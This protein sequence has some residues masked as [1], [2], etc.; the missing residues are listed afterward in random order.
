MKKS[1]NIILIGYRGTGKSS[2][3]EVLSR[4]TGR[5]TL[6][7]DTEIEKKY[8][9]IAEIVKTSGWEKFRK[10]E[11][12]TL[13]SLRIKGGIIDCGGGIIETPENIQILNK[14][15]KVFWLKASLS[16]IHK[17]LEGK[18]DRPALTNRGDFLQ[19]IEEVLSRR[20]S[21]YTNAADTAIDTDGKS[22]LKIA[23]EVLGIRS[24]TKICIPVVEKTES[25][26][27]AALK[28]A[29]LQADII[30]LRVDYLENIDTHA[31]ENIIDSAEKPLIITCRLQNQ[32]G[33]GNLTEKNRQDL[34]KTA[35]QKRVDFIDLE[36]TSTTTLS[37]DSG[38]KIIRSHHSFENTPNLVDIKNILCAM[39]SKSG[40]LIKYIPTANSINDNF[41]I[42]QILEENKNII[43]FCMGTKGHISRVL[44]GKYG[45]FITFAAQ[46]PEQ[47]SAPGQVG[48][49]ELV[50][51]Y[52]FHDIDFSTKVYGIIGQYA[53][54]S[55]SKYLHNPVFKKYG[56]HAVFL[57]FK[58]EP[59]EDLEQFIQNFRKFRFSGASVTI[60]HKEAVMP[61]LDQIDDQ[62]RAIGAVNTIKAEKGK[63]VGYN[64][65][66]IGAIKALQE[67]TS[68]AGKRVLVLGAGGAARAIVY[69]LKSE[70]AE[71][72]IANR[73][74]AKA[75]QLGDEFGAMVQEIN[76]LDVG[77]FDVF[78]NTTS[79]G[80][81]PETDSTILSSF[82]Q[83]SVVMDIVYKPLKTKFL[84][85]AQNCGC[86]I[87]TGE[88]MLIWQAIAQQ[89]IWTGIEPDY[90]FMSQCFFEI[91]D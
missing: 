52:Q 64:T 58:T 44:A 31:L 88:K 90:E 10:I 22:P 28:S 30:E 43:A 32:G 72:T 49:D 74:F 4:V 24:Q 46:T 19:E 57:P 9:P 62:A 16:T 37:A 8:G 6:S 53:E 70:L 27:I 11:T 83:Q 25:S 15:G 18:T 17:R 36:F 45:S 87:I 55:K 5:K 60:P 50:H 59:G 75:Q 12:E 73:T 85:I 3:A 21:L 65:D 47:Q 84:E 69:G 26:A 82:P 38:I 23:Y 77:E 71:V 48:L 61:L 51:L 68:L 20:I 86:E 42:F 66:Y 39:R 2:V 41:K 33:T 34:L 67:K 63:L 54:D 78:I 7:L 56:T 40:D 76:R 80:M 29:N 13:K 14:K 35:N 89:R 1:D 81:Y 79:L 91:E